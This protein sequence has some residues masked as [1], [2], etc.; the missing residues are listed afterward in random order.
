VRGGYLLIHHVPYLNQNKEIVFGTLV[1]TLTLSNSSKTST[2]DTHV[3]HFIGENP[4]DVN[5]HV[6]TAIQHNNNAQ[7]L[8]NNI[9]INRSFL[10]SLRRVILIITRRLRDMRI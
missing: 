1:S 7:R 9:T 4:C 6:L 3:I 8:N 2:P 10:I 5:G